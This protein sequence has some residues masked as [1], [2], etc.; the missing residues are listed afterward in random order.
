ML[1]SDVIL[2]LGLIAGLRLIEI[3]AEHGTLFLV[4]L[5]VL[6]KNLLHKVQRFLG[7]NH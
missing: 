1:Y 7:Y 2:G 4:L 3:F 5:E 6:L